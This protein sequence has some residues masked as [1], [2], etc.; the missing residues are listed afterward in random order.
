M[1]PTIRLLPFLALLAFCAG[2]ADADVLRCKD[3]AGLVTYTQGSCPAGTQPLKST[4]ATA[5]G[6]TAAPLLSSLPAAQPAAGTQVADETPECPATLASQGS[7]ADVRAC[8]KSRS[9]P[10]TI[11][12][13]QLRER[14]VP[15]GARKRW[16][17]DYLCLKFVEFPQ[18]AGG[19]ARARPLVTVST[20]M[21][22]DVLA[23]GFESSALEG[24]VFPTKVAAVEALCA[25]QK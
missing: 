22:G 9:L 4:E 19:S 8:S 13:A 23:P 24:Q 21:R 3:G 14:F 5:V 18:P 16:S 10:S 25:A 11:G 2:Q 7:D 17:G 6:K 15:I 20:T 12:W 1:C